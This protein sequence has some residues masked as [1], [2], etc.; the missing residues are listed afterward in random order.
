[1][2]PDPV[3]D[4]LH[5]V[6]LGLKAVTVH[7]LLLQSSDDALDQAILLRTMP[8]NELLFQPIAPNQA[9]VMP[10]GEGPTVGGAQQELTHDSFQGAKLRGQRLLQRRG[11]SRGHAAPEALP[12]AQFPA[13]AVGHQRQTPPT[14][15]AAPDPIQVRGPGPARRRRHRG[16][17][18]DARPVSNR[19]L[20][21]MRALDL[22]DSPHGVPIHPRYSCHRPI[23][24]RP[25][26]LDQGLD[27]PSQ[28]APHLRG[29]LGRPGLD[30]VT[31]HA[32]PA[33][34]VIHTAL[35]LGGRLI[36][37]QAR[38]EYGRFPQDD[39]QHQSRLL[40][41]RCHVRLVSAIGQPSRKG[42]TLHEGS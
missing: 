42:S 33:Q 40:C 11:Q 6:L 1:M 8:R 37:L 17:C 2:E 24:K 10:T 13:V 29:R 9:G 14:V 5:G 36:E 23:A 20:A 4:D 21:N 27:R 39:L 15:A 25:L 12:A 41:H 7:A 31:R 32:E 22:K 35:D 38:L 3:S 18:L 30:R 19:P 26:L 34:A 28:Y 16:Q